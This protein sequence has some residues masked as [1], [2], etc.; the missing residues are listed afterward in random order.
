MFLCAFFNSQYANEKIKDFQSRGSF[1]PRDIHKKIL[2]VGLPEFSPNNVD[3]KRISD[4]AFMLEGQ[5]KNFI[6]REKPPTHFS[7]Q[8]LGRIRLKVRD[9]LKDGMSEIDKLIAK[10]NSK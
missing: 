8:E 10:I 3:H 2:E 9:A 6:Q 1:G 7:P 5:S 4:L